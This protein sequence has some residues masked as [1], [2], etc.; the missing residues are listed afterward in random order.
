MDPFLREIISFV[1]G[2][3]GG[4]LVV[5]VALRTRLALMDVRMNQQEARLKEAGARAEEATRRLEQKFKEIENRQM[6]ELRVL[7]GIARKIGVDARFDD[8]LVRT[9]A[10]EENSA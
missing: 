2:G 1:V 9:I 6:F 5:V 10:G 8:L 4:A 3:L 7:S